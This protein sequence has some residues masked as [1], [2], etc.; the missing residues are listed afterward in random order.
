MNTQ[1]TNASEY[2][3]QKIIFGKVETKEVPG[4]NPPIKY[5][6]VKVSTK[7]QDGSVGDL[8][9][10]TTEVFSY[11]IQ[12]NMSMDGNSVNGHVMPLCLWNKDGKT[13]EED[14][15]VKGFDKTV[16]KIKTWLVENR[17]EIGKYDLDAGELKKLNPLYWKRERGKIVE[18][19]GP[20]LYPKLLERD[21]SIVTDFSNAENGEDMDPRDIL[22]TYCYVTAAIKIESI[23]IGNKISLQV[24][25]TEG[26]V[27]LLGAGKKRL[28]RPDAKPRV[29]MPTPEAKREDVAEEDGTVESDESDGSLSDSGD[30]EP[31]VGKK[32]PPAVTRKVVRR[33]PEK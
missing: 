30:D 26:D 3:V 28:L 33:K 21:G 19:R 14:A 24:K 8:V 1:L 25:M 20:T 31:D 10:A 12:E 23:Y 11:G 16:E 13:P 22:K 9:F 5:S 6:R 2:D 18:G 15:F 17:D 29:V 32:T 4:S 27:K 7:N